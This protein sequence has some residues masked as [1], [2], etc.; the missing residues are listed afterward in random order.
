M[1]KPAHQLLL[2][3]IARSSFASGINFN[4]RSITILEG[5]SIVDHGAK[6]ASA[7]GDTNPILG[8][9]FHLSS[10][11][12]SHLAQMQFSPISSALALQKAYRSSEKIPKV[13]KGSI[14]SQEYEGTKEYQNMKAKLSC[15]KKLG[16]L[17][18]A[19]LFILLED[20]KVNQDVLGLNALALL[21]TL[22]SVG[23]AEIREMRREGLLKTGK[24]NEEDDQAI[25]ERWK[26]LLRRTGLKE[27][28]LKKEGFAA[29]QGCRY[30]DRPFMLKRQ[31]L[32]FYLLQS[33][34]DGDRRLPMQAY[35]RLAVLLYGG[36][37]TKEDDEKILTWVKEHGLKNW[38]KLARI[39]D[40]RYAQASA[41]VMNRY[42]ELGGILKGNRN[43]VYGIEE[44]S[45]VIEE[46]LKQNPEAF[47]KRIEESDLNFKDIASL[48]GRSRSVLVSFYASTVHPTIMRHKFGT[49]E[50][51][52]RGDLIKEV[53]KNKK[54]IFSV[55]IEFDKLADMQK[56]KG[57][58]STSLNRLYRGIMG[59][60]VY[61]TGQKSVREVTVEQVEEYWIT[62]KRKSKSKSLIEKEQEIVKAYLEAKQESDA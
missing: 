47:E 58:N 55:D 22:G 43:G 33:L 53:K 44:I 26:T 4:I 37:F 57:H 10:T 12:F 21:P 2:S 29:I 62:S 41:S 6:T 18:S 42:E 1:L 30:P 16:P 40:R 38:T 35:N 51:D 24:F 39:M 34:K 56:F 32:G 17:D 14:L 54:W 20:L 60:V 7:F 59:N 36:T 25:I 45:R 9:P 13:R 50:K 8:K 19:S 49:L 52:V 5:N 3:K 31:A 48:I 23:N 61:K 46:V 11:A 15:A 27:E 28:D